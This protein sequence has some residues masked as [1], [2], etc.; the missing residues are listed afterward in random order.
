MEAHCRRRPRRQQR[1]PASMLTGLLLLLAAAWAFGARPGAGLQLGDGTVEA[2]ASMGLRHLSSA[3]P[4][5]PANACTPRSIE[6]FPPDLISTPAKQRGAILL[7]VCVAVWLFAALAVVCDE[8]FV[9]DCSTRNASRR[10]ASTRGASTSGASTMLKLKPDVAGATFMAAG[11]SAPELFTSVIG[12][13]FADSDVGVSTIV[14]S[15]VFNLLFIIGLCGLCAT[16]AIYLSWWPM[17]RDCSYYSLSVISLILVIYNEEVHWYEALIF[18]VMYCGYIAIM[19]LNERIDSSIA[20]RFPALA[21]G[22]SQRLAQADAEA[23]AAAGATVRETGVPMVANKL[24]I[25][26]RTQNF[27][28]PALDA[29]D[30]LSES[31]RRLAVNQMMFDAELQLQR[32]A[33]DLGETDESPQTV[34]V[35]AEPYESPLSMPKSRGKRIYWALMLPWHLVF[36]LSIPD[37]RRPGGRWRKIFFIT[38]LNSILW[39]AGMSYL[40]V[41]MVCAVGDTL[42]IP[43][44]VM[45]LTLLAAGTSV[46]DALSSIFT[47]MAEC[48]GSIGNA[49]PAAAGFGDMAVS[50]SVGSN[51]FDILMGLG[52][53]WLVS[54]GLKSPGSFVK[55]N[56]AGLTYS[57]VTLLSTVLFLFLSVYL[58]KMRLDRRLGLVCLLL[59]CVFITVSILF[60]TNVFAKMNPP[61]CPRS[62]H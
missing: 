26:A 3:L 52:L 62:R 31:G 33:S 51:V 40:L 29:A 49:L 54:T 55:I 36:A 25:L 41:W 46:P 27:H 7:H 48:Q 14:G 20:A 53:P 61:A 38:L 35:Q 57:S 58:N 18:L 37:C 43:D 59:Y 4:L 22:G 50:N 56:S 10:G 45:G 19:Y 24:A 30:D 2:G 5:A 13:F 9:A 28:N 6:T 16:Q 39:I 47:A 17:F 34:E 11:S 15:A 8:Y 60:E 21:T 12:V 1:L 23:A 42:G 32:S 44:T